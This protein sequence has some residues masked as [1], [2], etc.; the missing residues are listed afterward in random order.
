[1]TRSA[2]IFLVVVLT[3]SCSTGA[4]LLYRYFAD[5]E[6]LTGAALTIGFVFLLFV[7]LTFCGFCR[8]A[9]AP[10]VDLVY[11]MLG[12]GKKLRTAPPI[13]SKIDAMLSREETAAAL[14]F[15]LETLAEYPDSPGIVRTVARIYF[16]RL[17]RDEDGFAVI[18]RYFAGSE[19]HPDDE[20]APLLFLYLDRSESAGRSGQAAMLVRYQLEHQPERFSAPDRRYLRQRLE[21]LK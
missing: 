10:L 17:H 5:P 18:E 7:I 8:Y 11:R 12:S 2:R 9:D 14:A 21:A 15:A 3:L 6:D 13:L 20:H 1:M 19:P 16:E 4:A